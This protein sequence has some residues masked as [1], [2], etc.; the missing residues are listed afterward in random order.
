MLMRR[1]KQIVVAYLVQK[2]V[3]HIRRKMQQRRR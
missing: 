3:G 1:I 2:A